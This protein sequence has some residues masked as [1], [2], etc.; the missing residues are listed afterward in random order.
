MEGV[1][2]VTE[3]I[4]QMSLFVI[5]IGLIGIFIHGAS[6]LVTI[7]KMVSSAKRVDS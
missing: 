5:I 4:S 1:E 3:S 2:V 7:Y 6:L